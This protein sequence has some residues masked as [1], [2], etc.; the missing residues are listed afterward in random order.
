MAV[1]T[2]M[3]IITTTPPVI[4]APDITAIQGLFC[5]AAATSALINNVGSAA[6]FASSHCHGTMVPT[7]VRSLLCNASGRNFAASPPAS[8]A[9]GGSC[10]RQGS[11]CRCT[12]ALA[13][14][15]TNATFEPLCSGIQLVH[16]VGVLFDFLATSLARHRHGRSLPVACSAESAIVG[17][18]VVIATDLW[19]R[20]SVSTPSVGYNLLINLLLCQ[21]ILLLLLLSPP[22][23][24][25]GARNTSRQGLSG[26]AATPTRSA[27][28]ATGGAHSS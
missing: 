25:N 6:L 20:P 9:A 27:A 19:P 26:T 11:N 13:P 17:V 22:G 7:P 15:G 5:I 1:A 12:E 8:H 4:M 10:S 18:L 23:F 2:S 3:S 28:I 14:T 21:L 16:L 24:S